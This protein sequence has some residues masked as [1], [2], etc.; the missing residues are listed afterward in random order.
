MNIL[1]KS[2]LRFTDF[3]GCVV[4][5]K[6][7]LILSFYDYGPDI[8]FFVIVCGLRIIYLRKDNEFRC[9]III[10]GVFDGN[11]HNCEPCI[12]FFPGLC[13]VSDSK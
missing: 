1:I 2:K 7:H 4:Q 8:S 5:L 9:C 12:P 6:K 10:S 11:A 3:L 13:Q